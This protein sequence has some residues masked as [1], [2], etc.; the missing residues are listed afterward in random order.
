MDWLAN[1]THRRKITIDSAEIDSTL[2]DF[3]V[4]VNLTDANFDFDTAMSNGYDVRFTQSDALTP[5]DFD[6]EFHGQV[7]TYDSDFL[8]AGT[9]SGDTNG[10]AWADPDYVVDGNDST[11][12]NS[13]D[14]IGDHWWK[15]DLGVGV[16]KTAT[17]FR[18]KP[19]SNA[20]GN[21]VKDFKIQGSNNDSDWDDLYTGQHQNNNNWEDYV[22][23]NTTAYRY[24]RIYVTTTWTAH[25]LVGLF[26][27]E[28]MEYATST[29][30]GTYWVELPSISDL[31]DTDFYIYWGKSGDSDGSN[32]N[33]TWKAQYSGVW[34][35]N[36]YSKDIVGEF[37]DSTSNNHHGQGQNLPTQ[38]EG[39][40]H[41]GQQGGNPKN[42]R[43]TDS[44][45]FDL[46]S[47]DFSLEFKLEFPG[48]V[49]SGSIMGHDDGG[50]ANPKWILGFGI[51]SANHMSFHTDSQ[52]IQWA[53]TPS[54]DTKYHCVITRSGND[55]K[56]YVNAVQTGGTISNSLTVE[57]A[58]NYL[59]FLTDGESWKWHAG[60]LDEVRISKGTAVIEDYIESSYASDSD[61]LL[62]YSAE[63][64]YEVVQKT[65]SLEWSVSEAI[66][67]TPSL[68]W[69]SELAHKFIPNVLNYNFY[70]EI[71]K[72]IDSSVPMT[73]SGCAVGYSIYLGNTGSSGNTVIE[74]YA[75][76]ILKDTV[77]ISADGNSHS[78]V[79]YFD[80][81]HLLNPQDTL[82]IKVTDVAVDATDLKV[83]MYLMTFP[84]EM[85]VLYYSNLSD[86]VKFTGINKDYLFNS[87]DYWYIDF[88]QPISSIASVRVIDENGNEEDATYSLINGNFY[89]SRLQITPY[90]TSRPRQLR[91]KLKD[92]NETYHVFKVSPK[93][94]ASVADYPEYVT[95]TTNSFDL[96]IAATTSRYSFDGGSTWSEWL[97]ISDEN[98]STIDFTGQSAG[99]NNIKV[100]YRLGYE[101]IEEDTSIYYAIGDIQASIVWR[102]DCAEITYSDGAPLDLIEIYY[103]DVLAS[104]VLPTVISGFETF[105]LN[106]VTEEIEIDTGSIS[107]LGKVYTYDGADYDLS[108]IDIAANDYASQYIALFGF[109]TTL[110]TFETRLV[111]N[112]LSYNSNVKLS[113]DNFIE[114][115]RVD[116]G[117]A[118]SDEAMTLYSI[119]SSSTELLMFSGG[120]VKV[121]L[122]G[123]KD[124]TIR[125]KDLAGRSFDFYQEYVK[126]I[127]NL[128]RYL[129]VS[130]D[131][132]LGSSYETPYYPKLAIDNHAAFWMSDS[133]FSA[134]AWLKYE[135]GIG[136]PEAIVEA[137]ITADYSDANSHP[138]DFKIQGSDDSGNWTD[139]HTVTGE[140]WLNDGPKI[141]SFVNITE[142]A[143]YRL[144][145][146]DSSG[147]VYVRIK[148]LE[149]RKTIGGSDETSFTQ[150]EILPGELHQSEDL[151]LTITSDDWGDYPD[152]PTK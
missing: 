131:S 78:A 136:S 77:T 101:T 134:P 102:D 108:T 105:R 10:G 125:L 76:D 93:V 42:I 24:Y 54:A 70:Y 38:V 103:D 127:Y 67:K 151:N 126:T 111:A 15:Y 3:P 57:D 51:N 22:F 35:L 29:N 91:I 118:F 13:T 33:N 71:P 119:A 55:W 39:I 9:A 135:F 121:D 43:V 148:E 28:L 58:S 146:T 64:F 23:E 113:P 116:F 109:N 25:Y 92:Y 82:Q 73:I 98:K 88:N 147:G 140:T 17:K 142:Y 50:G 36:Q 99:A 4:L 130:K 66:Q 32:A 97:A 19:Y 89:M 85:D 30:R 84:F 106:K 2:T 75:E 139:L 80:L 65:P 137:A 14:T 141:Y 152:G 40:V 11:F 27:V 122:S 123:N 143:F 96:F 132:I 110:V 8:T 63:E 45:D 114:I 56:F 53:W 26:E 104:A 72:I 87:S 69:V 83:N 7:H 41:K 128:W 95:G 18:M 124:I 37:L 20:W 117:L 115:W 107:I 86:A 144:Y 34:H 59:T 12:G 112:S 31:V 138:K 21:S 90:T 150:T 49:T 16:T 68:E 120:S 81:S 133:T 74:I 129:A 60:I 62:T 6:R 79:E 61:A 47:D 100:Q 5:I 94:F 46:G 149:L 1:Y 145:I 48:S 44:A 52:W